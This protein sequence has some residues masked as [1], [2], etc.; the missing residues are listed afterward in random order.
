MAGCLIRHA[1]RVR[2]QEINYHN[3]IYQQIP[4]E[5]KDIL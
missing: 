5:K 2:D 4:K 1:K 3:T